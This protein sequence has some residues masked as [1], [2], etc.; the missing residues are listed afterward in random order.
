ME[1]ALYGKIL[2]MMT[3]FGKRTLCMEFM[4]YYVQES[5]G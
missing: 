5:V 2:S 1:V 3:A 4:E